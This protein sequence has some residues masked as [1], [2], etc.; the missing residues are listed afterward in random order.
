MAPSGPNHFVEI[1]NSHLDIY[2]KA[3]PNTRVKACP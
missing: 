3:T 2:E 1:T